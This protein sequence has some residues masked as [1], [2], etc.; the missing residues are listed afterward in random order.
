MDYVTRQFI[1]LTKK[2]RS[3]LRKALTDLQRAL[4]QQSSAI[5]DATEASKQAKDRPLQVQLAAELRTPE[6]VERQ[7]QTQTQ[8]QNRLQSWLVIAAWLTFTAAAIYGGVA[9]LQWREMVDA[10]GVAQQTINEARRSRLQSDKFLN[11]TIEQFQIEQRAW[12][13][14]DRPKAVLAHPEDT[15]PGMVLFYFPMYL[16]NVGRTSAFD[17]KVRF[18]NPIE[19]ANFADNESEI[20]QY[21]LPIAVLRRNEIAT[22]RRVFGPKV[23][24][25]TWNGY[26]VPGALA[27]SVSA[28]A[29]FI[30]TAITPTEARK[31]R[32]PVGLNY[33][34]YIIGRV[35][36]A[37]TFGS[38][39]WMKF[40]FY[41]VNDEGDIQN[42]PYGND[43]DRLMPKSSVR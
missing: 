21:Q 13:E 12:V 32:V 30:A 37:D 38:Q 28:Y 24:V 42:C 14:L 2:F 35:E 43:E 22:T 34:T 6:D 41:V 5:R 11:A 31:G 25:G 17:I 4:Q 26:A 10:T 33:F 8:I 39:H 18:T 29:P 23:Q 9:Y 19:S 1:H 16:R 36:Y 7:R 20:S 15:P 27:P 40:C 3:D